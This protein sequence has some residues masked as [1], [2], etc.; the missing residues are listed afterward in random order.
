MP[1][2]EAVSTAQEGAAPGT[3]T[4]SE[5]ELRDTALRLRNWG[6]WGDQD[7][8]GTV[9]LVSAEM[10]V[11]AA[12]LVQSG[13]VISLAMPFDRKG[14]HTAGRKGR[15]NPIHYMIQTGTD[16]YC[17]S[18]DADGLRYADDAIA[19]PTQC[20]TQWDALSHVFYDDDMY[21]GFDIRTVDSA[22]ARH[23]GIEHMANRMVGRGVLLDVPRHLGVTDLADGFPITRALLEQVVAAQGCH[24]GVGDF[25]L[26]RTGQLGRCLREGNWG[27]Y[28]GG[29]APGLAFDTLEWVRAL[30]LAAVCSDT[31]AVE[32]RPEATVH[33]RRPWHWVA[34]PN[35]GLSV[36]EIFQLDALAEQCAQL[37]RW[38][39]LF[40]AAPLPITGAVGSPVNPLAIL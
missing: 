10:I 9:N 7:E 29:N 15:Y 3:P 5:A 32:V 16:A 36:G 8:V 20:G 21:N 4:L 6:R 27:T 2:D 26:V 39:F 12:R 30:D 1:H 24:V 11:A 14:P 38:E 23:C 34:I 13:Q 22:G 28:A 40:V 19:M 17:G 33:I 35:M 37:G 31:F 18:Q 25:L